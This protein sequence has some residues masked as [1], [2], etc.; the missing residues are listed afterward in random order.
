MNKKFIL[1]FLL[2]T[3]PACN[4]AEDVLVYEVE[5]ETH[6]NRAIKNNFFQWQPSPTWVYKTP[7]TP[8]QDALFFAADKNDPFLENDHTTATVSVSFIEGVEADLNNNILRWQQQ[9]NENIEEV[10]VQQVEVQTGLGA[11]RFVR[12]THEDKAIFAAVW[13]NYQG[14]LF[15]KMQGVLNTANQHAE[16]FLQLI[17]SVEYIYE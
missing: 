5:K 11:W 2:I 10:S 3:L 4:Q 15:L 6:S 9:L 7:L 13:N 1:I 17:E 14:T 8:F 12:L 16:A